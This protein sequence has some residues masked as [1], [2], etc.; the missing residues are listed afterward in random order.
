MNFI[1]KLSSIFIVLLVSF[2]FVNGVSAKSESDNLAV[3]A[4]KHVESVDSYIKY[5]KQENNPHAEEVLNGFLELNNQEQEA[6]L[7]ILAEPELMFI[8]LKNGK[9][10]V[11]GLDIPITISNDVEESRIIPRTID[12]F[13]LLN[14]DATATAIE[15]IYVLNVVLTRFYSTVALKYN[16]A[17]ATKIVTS[18]HWHSNFNPAVIISKV[19]E[20]GQAYLT[21]GRAYHRGEWSM[22]PTGIPFIQDTVRLWVNSN[23][24]EKRKQLHSTHPNITGYSWMTFY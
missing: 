1:K 11:N 12:D 7:R 10:E 9:V 19:T 6:F 14:S 18:T 5:L 22:M 4:L 17:G 23:G 20:N 16:S 24:K 21:G 8:G 13:G 2:L 15:E 3:N